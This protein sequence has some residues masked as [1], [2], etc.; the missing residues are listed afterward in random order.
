[1]VDAGAAD[2]EIIHVKNAS[3]GERRVA[4]KRRIAKA[5]KPKTS[6]NAKFWADIGALMKENLEYELN[7]MI[8]RVWNR[9]VREFRAQEKALGLKLK[10]AYRK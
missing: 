6:R 10:K 3:T 5:K 1:M 4:T 7:R 2:F 9:V 8:P